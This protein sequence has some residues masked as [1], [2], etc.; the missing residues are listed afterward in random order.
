MAE[1]AEIMDQFLFTNGTL[2][3]KKILVILSSLTRLFVSIDAVSENIYD[4]V[5]VPVNKQKLNSG[6]LSVMKKMLKIR[7][8][9][10]FAW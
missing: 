9:E 3:N 5:R 1:E 7:K 4:K 8:I 2:L 6:R 10:K